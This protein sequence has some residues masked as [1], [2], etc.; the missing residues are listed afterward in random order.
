MT[1]QTAISSGRLLLNADV[2]AALG[3]AALVLGG[4]LALQAGLIVPALAVLFAAYLVGGQ[5][6]ARE[7]LE[8]LLHERELDVDLLMIVAA[9]GAAGLGLWQGEYHFILDGAILI[10]IFAVSGALESYAMERTGRDIKSLMR[11]APDQA[12][13]QRGGELARVAVADLAIGDRVLIRPGE[14]V[15]TDARIVEGTSALNQ[16]A[17]TGESLPVDKGPGEVIYAGTLNGNGTLIAQVD[18]P[19]QSSLLQR[20]IRLVEQAQSEEPPSQRSIE[21]FERL[22]ARAVIAVALVLVLVPPVAGLWDWQ[23]AIYRALIFLVVASPCALMAA[24][25]PALLSAIANGAR[26]GVLFKNA[27][28]VETLGRVR[29]VAFDK[30]GTLTVGQPQVT[31]I[32]AAAGETEQTVLRLAA[33]LEAGSEHPIGKAIVDSATERAIAFPQASA[34]QARTGLGIAGQLPDGTAIRVGRLGFVLPDR[35]VEEALKAWSDEREAQG[36]TVIWVAADARLT[37][38][39]AVAD[40]VRPEAKGAVEQLRRLGIEHIVMLSGDNLRAAQT[41]ADSLGIKEVRAGL[42][43]EDKVEAIRRLQK[44]YGIVAMVGDGI[45]DAPALAQADVGIA[46][47]GAG[48]DVALES[49]D[50]VL[51]ADRLEKLFDSLHLGRRARSVVRQNVAFAL[52]S[53]AVLLGANFAADLTLPLGVLGHEGSTLLVTL[54]GLRLLVGSRS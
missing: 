37:G 17:I 39:V 46:M 23:T 29:A 14:L 18:Q 1:T 21:R 49:A 30:T 40:R 44:Q 52:A 7:G 8:T 36:Q 3:C 20:V 13:V 16:A 41:I 50:V 43:P 51:M 4:W 19:P 2:L 5:G 35:P 54:S 31:G 15:P 33:A 6:P 53:V 45:N 11:L 38:A 26:N 34:V 10:L 42:L 9:L 27:A 47:G 24:T 48:S 22:Y 32:F 12:T 25:M 28:Q